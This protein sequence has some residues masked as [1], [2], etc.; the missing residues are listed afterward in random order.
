MDLEVSNRLLALQVG[1]DYEVIQ[2]LF[3]H[4]LVCYEGLERSL[5]LL[6]LAV[7]LS[8][9]GFCLLDALFD[10]LA[11]DRKS[12]VGRSARSLHSKLLAN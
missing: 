7:R 5:T 8:L 6:L 12:V 1:S 3:S 9:F 4:G 10:L 2:L 11:G